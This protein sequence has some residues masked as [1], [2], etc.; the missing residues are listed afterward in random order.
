MSHCHNHCQHLN[1]KYCQHCGVVY[2]VNCGEEWGKS[3]N[4]YYPN[5][6]WGTTTTIPCAYTLTGIG[7]SITTTNN[8][9]HEYKGGEEKC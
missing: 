3:N 9:S 7:G 6:S 2:C 5:Y 4:W 1:L 8:C